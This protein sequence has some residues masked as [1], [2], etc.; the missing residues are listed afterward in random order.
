MEGATLSSNRL[1]D[2]PGSDDLWLSHHVLI[3]GAELHGWCLVGA[4][5]TCGG[6]LNGSLGE[7]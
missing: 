5:Q 7:V 2:L 6:R 1:L 3:Y 4:Q